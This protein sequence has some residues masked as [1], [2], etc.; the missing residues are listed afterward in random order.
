MIVTCISEAT[1]A[2]LKEHSADF[3]LR[4]IQPTLN[5]HQKHCTVH[6]YTAQIHY[7]YIEQIHQMRCKMPHMIE[8]FQFFALSPY[9]IHHILHCL[10]FLHCVDTTVHHI[11]CMALPHMESWCTFHHEH[12]SHI[13]HLP[14]PRMS[15]W[16]P[17]APTRWAIED[18]SLPA[19]S[20]FS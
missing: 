14:S 10:T 15:S 18:L 19:P 16:P 3:V 1:V 9:Q 11:Y 5:I 2:R 8:A 13:I 4:V 7:T 6:M 17:V 12:R 20:S